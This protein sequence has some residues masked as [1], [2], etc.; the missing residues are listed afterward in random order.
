MNTI[1][2]QITLITNKLA[3]KKVFLHQH[4]QDTDSSC[5]DFEESQS[6]NSVE[7]NVVN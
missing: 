4:K 7:V 6:V 5:F 3:I 2:L 1:R